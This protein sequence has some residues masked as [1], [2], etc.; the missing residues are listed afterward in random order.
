LVEVL[1]EFF[2]ASL[3]CIDPGFEKEE[4]GIIEAM[5]ETFEVHQGLPC[6]RNF[7]I[8][9]GDERL[10]QDVPVG[11]Q[12]FIAVDGG[13]IGSGGHNADDARVAVE[14][15]HWGIEDTL[16]LKSWEV[17]EKSK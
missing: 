6:E 14:N 11:R 3:Q 2:G 13:P 1:Q 4:R 12:S 15:R 5:V 10:F 8:L 7:E 16:I 9:K 17:V